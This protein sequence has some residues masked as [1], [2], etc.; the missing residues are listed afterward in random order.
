MKP[1]VTWYENKGY[2]VT[3]KQSTPRDLFRGMF[4]RNAAPS[5]QFDVV[6]TMSGGSFV[7]GN[8]IL[9]RFNYLFL[10]PNTTA[11]KHVLTFFFFDFLKFFIV[12]FSIPSSTS[13]RPSLDLRSP[14]AGGMPSPR[15]MILEGGPMLGTHEEG[16][17][18]LS[19]VGIKNNFIQKLLINYVGHAA[20][21]MSEGGTST[22]T[23]EARTAA[24]LTSGEKT[25][26]LNGDD[27]DIIDRACIRNM[28]MNAPENK[29]SSITE[30]NVP[31]DA[32]HNRIF[33]EHFESW[34]AAVKPFVAM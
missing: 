18:F 29:R 33:N 6:H 2:E 27:D 21:F 24:A 31:G 13:T 10:D 30:V 23:T 22:S 15:R 32:R 25:L 1:Y 7:V 5:T 28:I 3:Q 26:V 4:L 12:I 20:R 9:G 14:S 17:N 8:Y 34:E 11:I 16:Y 19:S